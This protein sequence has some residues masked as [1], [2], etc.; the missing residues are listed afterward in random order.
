MKK[1]LMLVSFAL[2]ITVCGTAQT[3]FAV[4]GGVNF[5]TIKGDEDESNK[6]MAKYHLGAQAD[7]PVATDFYFQ[8]GLLFA[9]KG[10]KSK[11]TLLG[12]TFEAKLNLAYLEI[13]LSLVYKPEVGTGKLILGAGPY[14]AFGVGGKLKFE[15]GGESEEID[16]EFTND[17]KD[18]DPDDKAY[19]KRMDAGANI[20]AG[21]E[22]TPNIFVQA[23]A[24][25]GLSNLTPKYNGEKPDTKARNLGFGLSIGYRF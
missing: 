13:P 11:E 3:T 20:F 25:V 14:V 21:Y 5:Q 19:I 9:T 6:M 22:F 7:I 2:F 16:V 12:E 8:P 15:G 10:A 24:Q 23:N 18:S 4:R 1:I 17:V